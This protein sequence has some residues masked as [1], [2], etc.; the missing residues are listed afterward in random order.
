MAKTIRDGATDQYAISMAHLLEKAP[1]ILNDHRLSKINVSAYGSF[2]ECIMHILLRGS[3][4]Q[5]AALLENTEGKH[6]LAV[7]ALNKMGHGAAVGL[8]CAYIRQT[9]QIMGC[10]FAGDIEYWASGA[11]DTSGYLSV[12]EWARFFQNIA[13][14]VYANQYE[15]VN[16]RGLNPEFLN[17]WLEIFCEGRESTER[18]LRRELEPAVTETNTQILYDIR[19]GQ[20]EYFKLMR[21]VHDRRV[22]IENSLIERATQCKLQIE[23]EQGQIQLVDINQDDITAA[24]MGAVY[25]IPVEVDLP[26]APYIRL[27]DFLQ[28]FY[29]TP[30]QDA[31]S[32]IDSLTVQW[33]VERVI[34]FG[35]MDEKTFYRTKAKML[36]LSLKCELGCSF[37][38]LMDA[39]G[40]VAERHPLMGDF[41]KAATG[42]DYEGDKPYLAVAGHLDEFARNLIASMRLGYKA[43]AAARLDAN[44]FPIYINEYISLSCIRWGMTAAGFPHPFDKILNI[45][46]Q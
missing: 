2:E 32:V 30:R 9:C 29:C 3:T 34:E 36:Y 5:R 21:D 20:E 19:R 14:G 12:M 41:W 33:E 25:H 42:N 6:D 26:K 1:V 23:N 46:Q 10:E 44:A 27:H 31:K 15:K 11:L 7:P 4:L 22:E 39:I 38:F 16:T 35:H 18:S 28:T 43:D 37:D 24:N 8:I 40:A 13:K 45:E 17:R